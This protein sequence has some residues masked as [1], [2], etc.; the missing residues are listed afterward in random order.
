M[1]HSISNQLVLFAKKQTTNATSRIWFT[2]IENR[3]FSLFGACSWCFYFFFE[4][5][6]KWNF[7]LFFFYSFSPLSF[8]CNFNEISVRQSRR[9]KQRM[10][11]S[12]WKYSTG[13]NYFDALCTDVHRITCANVYV[14]LN[15]WWF[16]YS[17]R[18][19]FF[20]SVCVQKYCW[21]WVC[22]LTNTE[23]KRWYFVHH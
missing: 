21:R 23:N 10:R 6:H 18:F 9:C 5:F 17:V 14:I 1:A 13:S 12:V 4:K 20:Q 22:H 16:K 7:R 3:G 11:N 15:G 2:F 8:N 19:F